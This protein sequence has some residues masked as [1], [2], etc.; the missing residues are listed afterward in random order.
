MLAQCSRSSPINPSEKDRFGIPGVPFPVGVEYYRGPTPKLDVW[1][2]DF[3]HIRAGGF[4]IVRSHSYWNWM[5][6]RPGLYELDDFD[7]MFDLGEKHRLFIWLDV[8]LATHG[9]CP[10]WLTRE[11]P[12]MRVVNYRGERVAPHA[13]VAYPQ[14]GVIHCYDHPAWREYGGQ[15]IRH[16]VHRYRDRPSLLIWGLWDG[17]NLPSYWSRMGGGYPCYC[18]HTIARYKTWLRAQYTLDTLNERVLRRY[19]RWEDVAPPRSNHN[20]VEMLLYR[21]FHYENLADHLKWMVNEVK[22]IDSKHEVRAHGAWYP[23]PWDEQCARHVDSWGMSM[24]SND[25]LTSRDPEKIAERA[26]VFDWSR[27]VGHNGCWWNEEIYA[28]M[29]PGGVVWKKQSDPRETNVLLWMTLMGGASGAMY[30]Q[31][32]PEYLSFESPG[33]NLVAHDGKPNARFESTVRTIE[34]IEGMVDYLPLSCPKA[35]VG[36]VYHPESQE[37]F[38]YND[39]DERFLSDLRGVYRTLWTRGI[40]ADVI[41]PRMDWSGYKLLFLPNVTLMDEETQRRIARTLEESPETHLVAE[42]SFGMYSADGQ[43][44]YCPPEGFAD[45]LGV[46][47][48][49]F[50]AVTKFDIE[51][52]RNVVKTDYGP[53]SITSP[54][55]YAILEPHSGTQPIASLEG[56]TVG[57]RTADGRF[58][59]F[60]FTLSAG[61]DD[62]GHP[63]VTL[64]LVEE[65][66]IRSPVAFEGDH[67]VP[68]VRRSRS[69]GWLVFVLNLDR[70]DARARLFPRWQTAQA[71]DLLSGSELP[72]AENAIDLTVK[73]WEV[74]VIHCTER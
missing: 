42:G 28:G 12:D 53:A 61:F 41:T 40:P 20:V 15:L 2:E 18:E 54:C 66:G 48:A 3:A 59:W 58:T 19:R 64:G 72:I 44:S 51:Q 1:D 50:S 47:V 35:E 55:G 73:S 70:E 9:A 8:M 74:A 33:Y 52:G 6:P 34:Q 30:W 4:R 62:V 39:E 17:I 71:Y 14:G 7:R 29:H 26:F 5:E 45:R 46:R 24:P 68:V 23:R 21:R 13:G 69:G 25:L 16:M 49:D 27:S 37:L 10:E 56:E 32:R 36:I 43:S 22:Q 57:I 31:Y 11:H 67:I 60:G 38:G 65:L 63:Q